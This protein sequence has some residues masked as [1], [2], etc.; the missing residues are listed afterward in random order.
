LSKICITANVQENVILHNKLFISA[1]HV[2]KL[3]LPKKLDSRKNKIFAIGTVH[4]RQNKTRGPRAWHSA[5]I[6]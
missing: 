3:S 2:P 6:V 1:R 4:M 5:D